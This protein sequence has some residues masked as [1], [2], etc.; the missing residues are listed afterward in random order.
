MSSVLGG[1]LII[2]RL[3]LVLWGKEKEQ[4]TSKSSNPKDAQHD[5]EVLTVEEEN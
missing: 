1:G 3:Y 4:K 2:A 5:I